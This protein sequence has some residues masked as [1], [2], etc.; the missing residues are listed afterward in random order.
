MRVIQAHIH[1]ESYQKKKNRSQQLINYIIL[2]VL[3]V[4]IIYCKV[5]FQNDCL[6]FPLMKQ[7]YIHNKCNSKCLLT[8]INNV[9][10]ISF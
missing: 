1:T 4:E 8:D 9:N 7:Y 5:P 2:E 10:C 3:V 6:Q